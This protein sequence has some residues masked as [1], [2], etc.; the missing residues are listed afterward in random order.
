MSQ[1]E[2]TL[3]A[4]REN[5]RYQTEENER[6]RAWTE[7]EN[8]RQHNRSLN[9]LAIEQQ[10]A[11]QQFE[12]ENQEY[13]RRQEEQRAYD[14]PVAKVQRLRAAG[15]NPAFESGFGDVGS[16]GSVGSAAVPTGSVPSSLQYK[17]EAPQVDPAYNSRTT[18]ENMLAV[19][20]ALNQT[21][22]QYYDN[23]L[24]QNQAE[25]VMLQNDL[26]MRTESLKI[27]EQYARV[28]DALE[29]PN[30]SRSQY[31]KLS[32]EAQMLEETL[33]DYKLQ[34]KFNARNAD[35]QYKVLENQ[36]KLLEAQEAYE[37]LRPELEKVGLNIQKEQAVAYVKEISQQIENMKEQQKLT[38]QEIKNKVAEQLQT[39]AK[40]KGI[41]LE[42]SDAHRLAGSMVDHYDSETWKNLHPV[43]P[44]AANV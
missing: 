23:I 17:G 26:D 2:A 32:I 25:G 13:Q 4:N 37:V 18:E 29:R 27:N 9:T 41:K 11:I 35:I 40:T 44:R 16:V 39:E 7:A 42:Q 31:R 3:K 21:A 24:K 6:N 8:A 19:V 30:L 43:F 20:G 10:F 15:I 38:S 36:A 1:E 34:Q 5:I 14:D 28:L 33:G 22:S 12:R